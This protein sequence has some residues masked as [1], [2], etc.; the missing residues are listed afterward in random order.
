MRPLSYDA[1]QGGRTFSDPDGD[2]LRYSTVVS[3]VL[4]SFTRDSAYVCG[5]PPVVGHLSVSVTAEDPQG[6]KVTDS[7]TM[8]VVHNLPPILSRPNAPLI[9]VPDAHVNYDVTQ[10]GSTFSDPE[11]DALSYS[12][13]F[14][15]PAREFSISGNRLIGSPGGSGAVMVEITADDGYGGINKDVMTVAVAA[16]EPGQPV[17]PAVSYPYADANVSLPW[18][19]RYDHFPVFGDTTPRD[20]PTTDAGATLGRVLFYDK[21]LSIT[22][23]HACASCHRQE[24]GFAAEERFSTGVLGIPQ[25]RNAMG[26]ANVCYNPEGGYFIDARARSLEQLALMP[27]QAPAELAN[28]LPLVEQRL[29]G[30]NFYPRLFEAA[31]WTSEINSERIGRAIA[32]FLRSMLSF[33]SKWDRVYN[34]MNYERI[35]LSNASPDRAGLRCRPQGRPAPAARGPGTRSSGHCAAAVSPCPS[36]RPAARRLG[37]VPYHPPAGTTPVPGAPAPSAVTAPR[38]VHSS[39]DSGGGARAPSG[40]SG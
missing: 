30:T 38:R 18:Q 21:R 22:N 31:F 16:A 39:A 19:L 32:Q 35:V 26:L 37:S 12:I 27:I 1:S 10:G 11:G 25:K 7:F 28:F 13:S 29:A 9:T 14:L 36:V 34:G 3:G 6:A 4:H 5:T 20:N 15:S 2:A 8:T 33:R 40:R 24:H 17:L 23:T